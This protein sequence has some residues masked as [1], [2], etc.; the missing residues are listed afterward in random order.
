MALRWALWLW[1]ALPIPDLVRSTI[2]TAL[3]ARFLVGTNAVV[4]DGDQV[5]LVRHTYRRRNPW[6][7]PAGWVRRGEHPAEAAAR[8]V[9]EETGLRIAVGPTVAVGVD[10]RPSRVDVAFA[11]RLVGGSFRPSAEVSQAR[12][13][14]VEQAR[15]LLGPKD[16][17]F[18]DSAVAARAVGWGARGTRCS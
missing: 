6:G 12:F 18:L 17:A 3:N 14:G 11:C 13:V 16:R 1:G 2:L 8:E 9:E 7:L 4:F 15:P 10:D 5:L